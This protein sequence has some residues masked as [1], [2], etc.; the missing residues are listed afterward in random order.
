[1]ALAKGTNSY[2]TVAE[3]DEYF[4]D[5]LDVVAWSGANSTEKAK[6][7]VTATMYLD[8]ET[9]LGA[10]VS[11]SQDLAFPRTGVY[12]DPKVGAE[13]ALDTEY[14]KRLTLA[15]FELAYHF[16]NNDGILDSTGEVTNLEIAS[17]SLTK[18]KSVPKIPLFVRNIISCM[19]L[20]GGSNAVWRAN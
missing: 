4:A 15:L 1:M 10:A 8:Q 9:W 14:P 20:N 3:A 17:I 18:I 16:L 12:F 6:A 13:V 7:L 11:A 2:A 19:L 5:R